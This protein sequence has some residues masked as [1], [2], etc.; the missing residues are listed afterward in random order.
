MPRRLLL[1]RLRTLVFISFIWIIFGIVFYMNLM[2]DGNDLGI[3]VSPY[4]F[5]FTFG[6]IGLIIT[7]ALI[8]FLKPAFNHQPVWLSL[9]LKFFITLALLFII[10]F[11]CC[12]FTFFC[13]TQKVST[14]ISTA[15]LPSWFTPTLSFLL[16]LTW[17]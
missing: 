17:V 12:C 14:I 9:I 11:Y 2:R 1:Y 10:G 8:F 16:L 13:T 4:Q 5:A 6:I 3:R 15:F 7:A